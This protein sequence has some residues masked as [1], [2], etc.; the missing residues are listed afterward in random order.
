MKQVWV[1][2]KGRGEVYWMESFIEE[3]T[4]W[5]MVPMD[6]FWELE[7]SWLDGDLLE[8]AFV[9]TL[10]GVYVGNKEFSEDEDITKKKGKYINKTDILKNCKRLTVPMYV[11]CINCNTD[12]YNTFCINLE[13]DEE[14]DPKQ[15]Q[16][17]KSDYEVDFIPYGIMSDRVVYKDKTIY[18]HNDEEYR[19]KCQNEPFVCKEWYK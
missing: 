1:T 3:P 12:I 8:T 9:L 19:D 2:L 10:E 5:D 6:D 7:D 17:V 11:R 14:F 15:L 4:D 16:L 13:D 18:C